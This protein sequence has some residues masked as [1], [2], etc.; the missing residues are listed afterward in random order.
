MRFEPLV[1]DPKNTS[2]GLIT[3]LHTKRL[4]QDIHT[5]PEIWLWT[6]RRW[7][8]RPPASMPFRPA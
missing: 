4:E 6:H 8:H 7:K 5:R 1:A 3:E 2:E